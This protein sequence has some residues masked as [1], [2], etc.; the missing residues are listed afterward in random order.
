MAKRLPR[1]AR[2]VHPVESTSY[3]IE[4]NLGLLTPPIANA[5]EIHLII[6]VLWQFFGSAHRQLDKFCAV[7]IET[8]IQSIKCSFS[9]S[10]RLDQFGIQ[11]QGQVGR[12]PR[13]PH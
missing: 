5:F 12:N 1:T 4:I 7:A 6:V 11:Q 10:A 8:W 9:F 2:A 3:L 13:L